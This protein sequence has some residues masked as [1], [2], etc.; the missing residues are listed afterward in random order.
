MRAKRAYGDRPK[1]MDVSRKVFTG[2]EHGFCYAFSK[3]YHSMKAPL[4]H[5]LR[6]ALTSLKQVSLF[7]VKTSFGGSLTQLARA[8]PANG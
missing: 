5:R 3:F 2:D 6:V 7:V 8:R 4:P 1:S